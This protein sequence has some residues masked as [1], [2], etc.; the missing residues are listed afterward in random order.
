MFLIFMILLHVL[1]IQFTQNGGLTLKTVQ[2]G[3][4]NIVISSSGLIF[5]S[6]KL[7]ISQNN[8]KLHCSAQANIKNV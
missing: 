4:Q 6:K 3:I 8:W 7:K 5:F 2:H 1:L